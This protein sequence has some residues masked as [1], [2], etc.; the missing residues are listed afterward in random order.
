MK[1]VILFGITLALL[2]ACSSVRHPAP[3]EARTQ[4]SAAPSARA[5]ADGRP[6][7]YTIQKGDTLYSIA[8]DYGLDYKDIAK[9]NG[10]S[11]PS[12]ISIGQVLRLTS[13]V[14]TNV[15]LAATTTTM[16]SSSTGVTTAPLVTA[17]PV[18]GSAI[19]QSTTV[20]TVPPTD[21][22][23]DE[24]VGWAWPVKGQVIAGFNEA[25]GIK[26]IDIAGNAGQPI[27]ASAAGTVL[28]SGS[29]I[30]GYGRLLVIKHNKTYSS[31]YAHNSQIL[32]KEGDTV[33]RGQKIAEMGNTDADRVKLHFEIRKLGKPIDPAKLLP[34]S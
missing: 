9:W 28:Y 6:T 8:L 29:G 27:Y 13:P 21:S 12:V 25:A 4:Q 7:T 15:A 5:Y 18:S 33:A 1:K 11:D 26:G 16:P 22:S 23:D 10:I 17:P 30:R 34:P 19:Q 20:V 31:V 24:K 14:T 2:Q 3:V 32:V